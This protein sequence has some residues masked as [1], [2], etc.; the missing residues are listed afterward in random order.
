MIH[1]SY[2]TKTSQEDRL[3]SAVVPECL[4]SLYVVKFK[5]VIG[6]DHDLFLA[7]FFIENGM[8]LEMMMCFS[9]AS[10]EVMVE[11]K[12]KLYSICNF[13]SIVVE[14]VDVPF[15]FIN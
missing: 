13:I 2:H 7:K 1:F 15:Q 5:E 10:Q 4:A 9:V 12:K 6:D 3:S 8:I 14:F 11:F